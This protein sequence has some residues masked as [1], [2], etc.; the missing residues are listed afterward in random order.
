MLIIPLLGLLTGEASATTG[1]AWQWPEGEERRFYARS[2]LVLSE[3][4]EMNAL[5]NTDSVV[6]KV[7]LELLLR[8]KL[9]VA[10]GKTAFAIRCEIDDVALRAEPW[11]TS[12]GRTAEV[13]PEWVSV[14]K[15]Q[16]WIQIEQ[17]R[18]GRIRSVDLEGTEKRISRM[19][20]I[21]ENMRLLVSRAIAPFDVMLPKKGDD[22]GAGAWAQTESLVF[23]LPSTVGTYG[24][25]M[26]IHQV[27][28]AEEGG[29]AIWLSHGEGTISSGEQMGENART[30]VAVKMDGSVVFDTAR[31]LILESQY[32]AEGQVTSSSV[33]AESAAAVYT[34]ASLVQYLDGDRPAP[35]FGA[36]GEL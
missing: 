20:A 10:I 36:S 9:D 13:I 1:L 23:A 21:S 17:G 28:R 12:R 5:N 6:G 31:G 24:A 18:N 35:K 33:R 34:Q 27:Q 3:M 22:M 26:I 7:E 32:I 4:F 16:A 29:K 15:D 2:Q 14:L 25:P 19:Q 11:T 8:C 30:T